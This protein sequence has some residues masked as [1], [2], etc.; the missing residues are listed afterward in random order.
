M[1][2]RKFVAVLAIL[3]ILLS[4]IEA[5]PQDG[6]ET[7]R[8]GGPE[9]TNAPAPMDPANDGADMIQENVPDD[10]ELPADVHL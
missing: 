7:I 9:N 4:F 2:N 1:V 8:F 3:S 6:E 10:Q 5:V